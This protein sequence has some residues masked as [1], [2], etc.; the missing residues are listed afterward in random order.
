M[1]LRSVLG[2]LLVA[3]V[4]YAAQSLAGFTNSFDG[5]ASGSTVLL[6]WDGA[7]AQQY[8]L[9]ITAQVIDKGGDGF[10]ANAYQVNITST[11]LLVEQP[12]LRRGREASPI[13]ISPARGEVSTYAC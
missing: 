1:G 11:S 12:S 3:L 6:A 10:S 8:P 4:L 7:Q 5:I 2:N 9:Y 13:L